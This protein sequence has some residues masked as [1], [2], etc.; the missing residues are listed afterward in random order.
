MEKKNSASSFRIVY[1]LIAGI[2]IGILLQSFASAEITSW[3]SSNVTGP[4]GNFFLRSLF[5][6]VVPL[7]V[8]SL[9]VGV[10]DLGSIGNLGRY[11]KRAG[12]FYLSTTVLAV[13]IGQLAVNTFQPGTGIDPD[14]MA[15]AQVEFQEQTKGLRLKSE[16]VNE[17]LWPGLID[18]VV[19]KNILEEWAATNML[20]VI[21]VSILFGAALLRIEGTRKK[22]LTDTLHTISDITIQVVHW[23]MK[24]APLAVACLMINAILAFNVA[25]LGNL[26]KYM[27]VVVIGYGLHFFL[28]YGLIIK[29]V[30]KLNPLRFYKAMM[31]V[32]LTA[33]STSSSNATLPTTIAHLKERFGVPDRIVTFTAP[34]GATVNM[35][36]TSLF[37]VV[38]ALF[39]AQVFG[40]DLTLTQ[41]LTVV[42]LVVIT[43]IGVAGVPGGS[44]PLLMSAMAAVGI[45]PEGIALILGVDRILD[46]GRT[47]VNVT[48]DSLCALYLAKS[49]NIDLESA[50]QANE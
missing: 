39:I 28:S 45:P 42:V 34:L 32:F 9:T 43:S 20:S 5:M 2:I 22:S 46:M 49:D 26:A 16:L 31:P 40:I 15:A 6:I 4:I 7:V 11:G 44:I 35:D 37:E 29:F 48:G 3:L 12:L 36:G 17:S 19:P 18:K 24:I 41:H 14:Y 10:S 1:G 25:I 47:V 30:L 8:S 38:A 13:L 21:F 33:F 50:L 23:I 27:L